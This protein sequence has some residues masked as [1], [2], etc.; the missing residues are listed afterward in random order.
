MIARPPGTWGPNDLES[1]LFARALIILLRRARTWASY[2]TKVGAR[3]RT[4]GSGSDRS[5]E[6]GFG[7]GDP[8]LHWK[9]RSA[10]RT[11]RRRTEQRG[12]EGVI[13]RRGRSRSVRAS[14]AKPA[15][16]RGDS[17][18]RANGT[19][20]GGKIFARRRDSAEGVDEGEHL[21]GDAVSFWLND[22]DYGNELR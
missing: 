16:T 19:A 22:D 1:A 3:P 9:R 11:E 20:P 15:G 2:A 12:E 21:L 14:P 4:A 8:H 7:I 5:R 13:T 17:R 6:N 18:A 10:R